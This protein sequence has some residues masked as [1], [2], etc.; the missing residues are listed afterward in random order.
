MQDESPLY[1]EPFDPL[2]REGLFDTMR[3]CIGRP[4]CVYANR[5]S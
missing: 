3:G 2:C 5:V 1:Y 4:R